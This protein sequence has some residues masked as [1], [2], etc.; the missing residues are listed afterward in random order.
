MVAAALGIH[1]DD[2]IVW[3]MLSRL[4]FGPESHQDLR[5]QSSLAAGVALQSAVG[6]GFSD[7]ILRR[8]TS[9]RYFLQPTSAYVMNK[10]G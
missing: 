5:F 7:Q 6:I 10:T 4:L 9:L 3:A 1:P 2:G 8:I